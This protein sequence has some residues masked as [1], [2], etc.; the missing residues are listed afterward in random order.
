MRWVLEL[1][2]LLFSYQMCDKL[3][4]GWYKQKIV[5]C[6]G[7]FPLISGVISAATSLQ[8]LFM[9]AYGIN[10]KYN[11]KSHNWWPN[12]IFTDF[13][14]QRQHAV[15]K[16]QQRSISFHLQELTFLDDSARNSL[17]RI[18]HVEVQISCNR[19]IEFFYINSLRDYTFIKARSETHN[20]YWMVPN[21]NYWPHSF[22]FD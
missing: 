18:K 20:D 9:K 3:R 16:I 1:P 12:D 11:D 8:I 5:T 2:H 19:G 15:L 17:V 13:T 21:S 4:P 10:L 6:L 7:I 22:G 14:H